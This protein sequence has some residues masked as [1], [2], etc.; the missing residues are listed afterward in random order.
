MVFE[1]LISKESTLEIVSGVEQLFVKTA[2][3]NLIILLIET[4]MDDL[5]MAGKKATLVELV[6]A[7]WKILQSASRIF[8]TKS[9]S[10]DAG[11][12]GKQTGT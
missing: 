8:M 2:A 4:V 12:Q 9:S 1:M 10:M 6:G 3:E 7:L 11:S 5:L